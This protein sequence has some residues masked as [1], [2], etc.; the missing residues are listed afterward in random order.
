LI[1]QSGMRPVCAFVAAVALV[2]CDG[3]TTTSSSSTTDASPTGLWSGTDSATGLTMVGLI[4]TAG[5][6]DFIRSDGVQFVGTAQV[7]GT[8]LAITLDGYSNFVGSTFADGSVYGIGTLNGTVST[9]SSLN[10]TMTFTTNGGT[11]STSTWS[12]NFASLYNVASSVSA[13]S[14]TYTDPETG[15]TVSISTGG[16]ISGQNFSNSCVLSGSLSTDNASYDLYT[17]AYSYTSCT[18]ADAALNGVQFTGL[19][20]RNP[21]TSPTQII[22]GVTGQ[23]S[24]THYGLISTLNHN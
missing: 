17:V 4:N 9:A 24:T 6:A 5:E 13:A 11:S 20:Y 10:G 2:A 23:S 16:V 8:T 21:N 1:H 18:G 19:A 14:G 12:L 22:I 3:T 15:S 7:S